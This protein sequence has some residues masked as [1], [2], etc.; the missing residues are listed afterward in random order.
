M[1][2]QRLSDA[3]CA[4]DRQRCDTPPDTR[5]GLGDLIIAHAYQGKLQIEIVPV[6]PLLTEAEAISYLRL[7]TINIAD[8]AATLRRYR[9]QGLLRGTQVS[10]RVFYL[11]NELDA[12][13]RRA[14]DA[15]P[16]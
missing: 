16:R 3:L 6:S 13:L 5:N 4:F 10:K 7:D 14:T 9:E 1:D 15:N 8:P 2:S 12:F 11:R